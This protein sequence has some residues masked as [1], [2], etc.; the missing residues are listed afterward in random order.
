[1]QSIRELF[2]LLFSCGAGDQT[3]SLVHAR[4]ALP[5]SYIPS[6]SSGKIKPQN[7]FKNYQYF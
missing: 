1:M 5:L 7:F 6:P 4:S 2:A 3:Q